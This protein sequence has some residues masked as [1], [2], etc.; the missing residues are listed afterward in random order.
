MITDE[1]LAE[2]PD[3]RVDPGIC[4]LIITH[5]VAG[6]P[7]A[8]ERICI[9]PPHDPG[10]RAHQPGLPPEADRHY[11]VARWPNRTTETVGE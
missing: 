1:E 10:H 6:A 8:I 11:L 5:T 7:L 4:G 2:H 3:P 9:R